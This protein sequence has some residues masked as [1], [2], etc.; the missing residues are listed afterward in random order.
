[1]FTEHKLLLLD[2][3]LNS[4]CRNQEEIVNIVKMN[5]Y[6]P[7]ETKAITLTGRGGP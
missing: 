4:S 6:I 1:M 5:L 3:R 7:I 2:H